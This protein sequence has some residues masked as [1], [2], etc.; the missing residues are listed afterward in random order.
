LKPPPADDAGEPALVELIRAEI[1]RDGPITFARFMERALY[2]PGLGYYAVSA[3]R[4]TRAGDFLTAPE[5]HPIF[6]LTVARQIDEMWRL[7]GRPRPF[8]VRE[9]GAGTGALYLAIVDGLPTRRWRCRPAALR[10]SLPC[11]RCGPLPRR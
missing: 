7:M 9:Y 8:V 10:P 6:G 4:P 5:L 3:T 1:E 2:E 11:W